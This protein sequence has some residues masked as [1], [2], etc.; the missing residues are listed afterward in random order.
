MDFPVKY[1]QW[2][3]PVLLVTKTPPHSPGGVFVWTPPTISMLF[4]RDRLVSSIAEMG[5][6]RPG[7][8]GGVAALSATPFLIFA[9]IPRMIFAGC[10]EA[11]IGPRLG[12]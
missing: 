2:I 8:P 10:S 5:R 4:A 6:T 12:S 1:E 11:P 7:A 9:K 3:P